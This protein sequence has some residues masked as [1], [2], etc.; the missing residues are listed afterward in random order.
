MLL[1]G[2]NAVANGTLHYRDGECPVSNIKLLRQSFR[3]RAGVTCTLESWEPF[4]LDLFTR[5]SLGAP[6]MLRVSIGDVL[7]LN[8][9][10]GGCCFVTT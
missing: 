8:P 7:Q 9:I 2:E 10:S 5:A 1:A 6:G 3:T 4:R